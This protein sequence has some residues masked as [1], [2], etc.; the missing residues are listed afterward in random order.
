MPMAV[1]AAAGRRGGGGCPHQHA[2]LHFD[3]F[4][5]QQIAAEQLQLHYRSFIFQRR[6]TIA[7][8]SERS[9]DRESYGRPPTKSSCGVSPAAPRQL[10]S[11]VS[12]VAAR[13]RSAI[14]HIRWDY[15]WL[16]NAGSSARCAPS[17]IRQ[18]SAQAT[19]YTRI[20]S[21]RLP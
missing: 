19:A 12:S 20:A 1:N 3:W 13:P 7:W 9:G 4:G 5:V 11:H 17:A 18:L 10:G 6:E 16:S 14:R 21:E 2:M 8:P 15:R